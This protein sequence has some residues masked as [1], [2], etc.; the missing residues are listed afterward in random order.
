MDT[1]FGKK[2]PSFVSGYDQGQQIY[3]IV[4]VVPKEIVAGI[5]DEIAIQEKKEYQMQTSEMTLFE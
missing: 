3:T 1:E 5:E 4:R 2:I